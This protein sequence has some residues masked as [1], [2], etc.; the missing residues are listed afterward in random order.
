M[1]IGLIYSFVWTFKKIDTGLRNLMV[2]NLI[3]GIFTDLVMAVLNMS[4]NVG[5]TMLFVFNLS[6][7]LIPIKSELSN[8]YNILYTI[9]I[10]FYT[11]E[12]VFP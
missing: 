10:Y 4:V 9:C 11:S 3:Y 2:V 5:Q 12:V 7:D 6:V 8:N 1:K